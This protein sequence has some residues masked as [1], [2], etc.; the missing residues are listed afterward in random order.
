MIVL[1]E[2]PSVAK[3]I[4]AGLGGFEKVPFGEADSKG[5]RDFYYVKGSDCIVSSAGHLLSLFEPGD[6]DAKYE[7]WNLSDLPIIPSRYRYK[8]IPST[9]KILK[10][11]KHVFETFDNKNFVLAT[12]AEREGEH[13][14]CLILKYVGF[15]EYSS[16]RR[17]WVSE[18]LTPDVVKKGFQNL[19]PLSDYESYKKAGLARARSDWLLGMNVS[20]LVALSTKAN[21]YFGRIQTA[22]L[23]AIYARDMNIKNFKSVPYFML[24]V[25]A[26]ETPFIFEENGKNKFSVKSALL[27]LAS[28]L[29]GKNLQVTDIQTDKKTENPPQL[30][31]ITGLQ[32]HCADAYHL[33][34]EETLNIAQKLY[35]TYKC[36][37]YPRTPSVVLGDDNVELFKEKF[38][39]LKEK[40]PEKA[41][42]C[43]RSKITSENKRIFNSAKL[44]D[45]HALIPLN[46]LPDA[47]SE[48]EKNVY[49]AVLERFFAVIKPPYEYGI[50]TVT[51]S[52][53]GKIFK[54][55]GK[56]VY[57]TGWKG[58]SPDDK[59][60]NKSE[61]ENE[62]AEIPTEIKKG[63]SL[64][65]G[66]TEILEKMTQ[67]KKHYT[68]SSILALMENPKGEDE[69]LGKLAG[70]GTPATRAGFIATLLKREYI[71]QKGQQLL[72]TDKGI[73]L[74]KTVLKIPSLANLIK[75][76]TTTDWEKKLSENPE[77]FLSDNE[78]FLRGE[79]PKIKITEVY[80]RENEGLCGCPL[81]KKGKVLVS[82][83]TGNY[84]C[85]AYK[86][87]H[88][89]IFK[90]HSGAAISAAD[91]LAL[92]SGKLTKK[93]KILSKSGKTFEA[94]LKGGISDGKFKVSVVF[95]DK[96]KK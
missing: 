83:K 72:I 31:N 54:A 91:A 35:E 41:Q 68:N 29:E 67:P 89:V 86:D 19:K 49:T 4:A 13:I 61:N 10:K 22:I 66:K 8:P 21:M 7:K 82:K 6:Y 95:D 70:I 1:T 81:C 73:F 93:K 44:Q 34:P 27:N 60:D 78:K 38:N 24:Q 62:E 65:I 42:R 87:C 75:L 11:I 52:A 39:L 94:R 53:D 56:T 18:A 92:C 84:F 28:S 36:L 69:N 59:S 45:H 48:A 26:G 58:K 2:K 30:F 76:S 16:A 25:L 80:K 55:K 90:E 71:T 20:R 46:V 17:F 74:I 23:G 57:D 64:K 15:K 33:T 3:D 50:T 77:E 9:L 63:D 14:G 43:A 37:S 79:L 40:Y 88:F 51:A 5:R 32:K 47:A 96:N 85:S 12:D